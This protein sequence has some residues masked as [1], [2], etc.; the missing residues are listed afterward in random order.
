MGY[1][2]LAWAFMPKSVFFLIGGI[3]LFMLNGFLQRK[4]KQILK[5]GGPHHE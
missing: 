3:L 1:F 2:N 4:K 5:N